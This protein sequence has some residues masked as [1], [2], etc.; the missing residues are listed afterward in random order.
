MKAKTMNKESNN[1]KKNNGI[2]GKSPNFKDEYCC[3]IV[4]VGE[5]RPI[6][7]SDFLGQTFVNGNSVV[8]R[9]DQVKQ[10]DVYIYAA[11]ETQL[12]LLFLAK[13]N[14]FEIG[15]RDL[16]ANYKEVEALVQEGK[17]DEAKRLVG[18]FTKHG[19]VKMIRLRGVPSMGFLFGKDAL[20]KYCPAVAD[21]DLTQHVGE[22]F[23]LVDGRL[24]VKA[25]VPYVRPFKKSDRYSKQDRKN[26]KLF[27]RLIEGEFSLHYE[28]Q[29]L[30][31]YIAC[32]RPNDVLTISVKFHGTSD[33]MGNVLTR[34][35]LNVSEGVK[36]VNKAIGKR[37]AKM[38]KA[39]KG[40]TIYHEKKALKRKIEKYKQSLSPE[41]R[42]GYGDIYSSRT[43]IK[44][45]SINVNVTEGY[46]HTDIWGEYNKLLKKYIP[47]GMTVYSEICGYITGEQ[48]MIQRNYDYG[49]EVGE[50]FIMP[51]RITTKTEDGQKREWNVQEVYDWTV[52]LMNEHE[53]LKKKMRPIE[54]LYHGT[55]AQLYPNLPL[56]EHWH[57]K[58]LETMRADKK[59][60]GM[61]LNEPLCKHKVPREGIC[62]RKDNDEISECWKLK[63]M[64]FLGKESEEISKGVVDIEM[65][66]NNY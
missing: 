47:H 66:N 22:D 13:N 43:I 58:V 18:F 65:A 32:I 53:E 2:I 28:T 8:V 60:F 15:A 54:I 10:G 9:K 33:I 51:Y 34:I 5:I 52:K 29:Q 38:K 57:E 21:L 27:N 64:A 49:C 19:R 17:K 12:S 59:N 42:I 62:V 44:N 56:G 24:F 25:Y 7:G 46:Y 50:N 23:D 55:L 26:V 20:E 11:N 40:V 6:E 36:F 45:K 48:K 14:L 37:I 35:P 39:N 4:E 30:Q 61:E 3:S 31:K 1:K 16:N 63:T 41:A